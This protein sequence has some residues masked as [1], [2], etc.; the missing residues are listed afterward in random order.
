VLGAVLAGVWGDRA[1]AHHS[2]GR[3]LLA[4]GAAALA[5]PLALAAIALPPDTAAWALVLI[6]PAYGLLQMYYGLVYAALN[7]VVEP[8]LRGTAMAFYLMVTYLGGAAF[9]P[10]ATGHPCSRAAGTP[11]GQGDTGPGHS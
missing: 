1:M 7:D 6:M 9:G 10:L 11:A 3:L 5:A 4:A 2:N 8:A